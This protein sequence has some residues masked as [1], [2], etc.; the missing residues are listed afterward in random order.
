MQLCDIKIERIISN[1]NNTFKQYGNLLN[2]PNSKSEVPIIGKI[3]GKTISGKIDRL[4]ITEQ[5]VLIID[6]KTG[7]KNDH[8]ALQYQGQMQLYEQL[9]QKLYPNTK[10]K[11]QIV[12]IKE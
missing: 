1:I 12:W 3:N 2:H 6:F 4:I 11:S 5:E 10:I 7:K 9:L 8:S